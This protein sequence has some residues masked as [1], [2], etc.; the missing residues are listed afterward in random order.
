M[1]RGHGSE[2]IE[3]V[4]FADLEF[5]VEFD[6]G[7]RDGGRKKGLVQGGSGLHVCTGQ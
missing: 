6:G 2:L 4:S 5:L 3:V 1:K 7:H